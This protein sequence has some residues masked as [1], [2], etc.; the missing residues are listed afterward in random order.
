MSQFHK[1]I[2]ICPSCN[3]KGD[4]ICWKSINV[5][6]NPETRK[7]VKNGDLFKYTCLNCGKS[8]NIEHETLYHDMKNKF[9]VQYLI[10]PTQER[11]KEYARQVKQIKRTGIN[12]DEKLRITVDKN[13]FIEK[14][15]I[16][17]SGLEDYYIELTKIILINEFNKT[18]PAVTMPRIYFSKIDKKE[19]YFSTSDD[20]T[21]QTEPYLIAYQMT[22]KLLLLKMKFYKLIFQML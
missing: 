21:L 8:Y 20:R 22:I 18:N 11:L 1:E 17:E 15:T 12:M 10:N 4:F 7:Q 5:D 14:I 6:L 16:F 9:M 13:E 2:I 19:I 3:T